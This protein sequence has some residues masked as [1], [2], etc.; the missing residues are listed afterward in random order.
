[1]IATRWKAALVLVGVFGA[2]AVSGAAGMRIAVQRAVLHRLQAPRGEAVAAA[3][4]SQIDHAVQLS[5]AQRRAI[6]GIIRRDQVRIDAVRRTVAPQLRAARRQQWAEVRE[7]LTDRQ[8]EGFDRWVERWE[9]FLDPE[10]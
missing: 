7:V 1:M 9:G 6:A 5:D 4:V 10:P 8:R 3:F 2:G